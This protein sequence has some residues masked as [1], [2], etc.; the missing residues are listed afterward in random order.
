MILISF[1]FKTYDFFPIKIK[2]SWHRCLMSFD[3]STYCF[4]F[5]SRRI[6]TLLS[7]SFAK[8]WK[9]RGFLGLKGSSDKF[10]GISAEMCPLHH[11]MHIWTTI[12]NKKRHGHV[13]TITI[14][15]NNRSKT[16]Y[17][18]MNQWKPTICSL[19]ASVLKKKK[20][21]RRKSQSNAFD[22]LHVSHLRLKSN[23]LLLVERMGLKPV[24]PMGEAIVSSSLFTLRQLLVI[25]TCSFEVIYL[26]SL[27]ADHQ[28]HNNEEK[29]I[30]NHFFF[31][32]MTVTNQFNYF[33]QWLTM[34]WKFKLGKSNTDK[35]E[36]WINQI[37][38]EHLPVMTV[39][40][41]LLPLVSPILC[42]LT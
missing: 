27:F 40:F 32:F 34:N 17:I 26:S 39:H 11:P 41:L 3:S 20:K 13:L 5:F 18:W 22:T 10:W 2:P 9:K 33:D 15:C 31:F 8:E 36:K 12:N 42:V 35:M 14:R 4:S 19:I 16:S 6:Q 37:G 24:I 23:H 1:L 38:T 29:K 28:M 7:L 21:E 25:T 30:T